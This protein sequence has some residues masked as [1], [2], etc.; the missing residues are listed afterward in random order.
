MEGFVCIGES[1]RWE[2]RWFLWLRDFDLRRKNTRTNRVYFSI[3]LSSTQFSPTQIKESE[4]M[5]A[6]VAACQACT[7]NCACN[8]SSVTFPNAEKY[9]Y[10]PH[11][12]F[13]RCI[14][15]Q[16]IKFSSH[17]TTNHLSRRGSASHQCVVITGCNLLSYILFIFITLKLKAC[18][19]SNIYIYRCIIT[20]LIRETVEK[21]MAQKY[22]YKNCLNA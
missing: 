19:Q 5:T 7:L 3:S 11:V 14:A 12:Q 17:R 15:D 21:S 13:T 8:F 1:V 6:A 18:I 10:V 20:L 2:L 22:P 16:T 9:P 4:M